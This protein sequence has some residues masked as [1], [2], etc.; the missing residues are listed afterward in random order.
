VEILTHIKEELGEKYT[1][2]THDFV[3]CKPSGVQ[4]KVRQGFEK[5]DDTIIFNGE[6]F[7]VMAKE[8]ASA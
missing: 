2:D 3:A 8:K 5:V 7:V 6:Y 1:P 4:R